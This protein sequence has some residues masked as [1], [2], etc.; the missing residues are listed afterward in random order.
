VHRAQPA[1]RARGAGRH[2][3]TR[4]RIL[5]AIHDFLPRHPAGSEIYAFELCRELS[6]RHDVFLVTAELDASARHGTIRWRVQDGLPVIEIVNNWQVD[7]FEDTY[8]SP[9]IAEQLEGVLDAIQPQVL[10]VHN[11]LNLSFDFPRRARARGI[12]TVATLHD[13]ALVCASGGQRV[14]VAESHVCE[15]IDPERCSRCFAASPYHAL[16]VASRLSRGPAG[17]LIRRVAPIA[18]RLLPVVTD[19]AARRLPMTPATPQQI[20]ARLARAR[21]VFGEIDLFVSPSRAMAAEF[22]RLGID[23]RR[24]QVSDYGFRAAPSVARGATGPAVRF[25]FVGTMAWHKGAHVLIEAA[26]QVRGAFEIMLAGD[27]NVGPEYFARLRREAAGLPVRFAGRFDRA[28]VPRVYGGLDVL[29][30]PSLWPENSPLV[31]HEA[32]MHG[33]AVVGARVGGIPELVEDGVNGFLYDAFSA[34]ALAEILQR[35]VDD[36]ALAARLAARVP[37]VK[38]IAEDARDWEARYDAVIGAPRAGAG[39]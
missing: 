26:R 37:A 19:A 27:P 9:R 11:L 35:F 14:H 38:S 34:E 24:M 32:F 39:A 33:V 36:P 1:A 25:G 13:Y 22:V 21:E 18:R 17:G 29:V 6:R 23:P 2:S 15:I 5:H 28:D 4:R 10:H 31:I 8:L 3:V 12:P 20:E 16:M 7:G 30:V